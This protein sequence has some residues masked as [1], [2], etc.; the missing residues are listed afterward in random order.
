MEPHDEELGLLNAGEAEAEATQV[1][2]ALASAAL[3]PV[4]GLYARSAIVGPLPPLARASA[5]RRPANPQ[6]GD[7]PRR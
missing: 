7:P 3:S 4:S 2:E 6:R 5:E 1:P